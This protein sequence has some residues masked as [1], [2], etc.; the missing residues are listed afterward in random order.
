[1][2]MIHWPFV[3]VGSFSMLASIIIVFLIILP[4]KIPVYEEEEELKEQSVEMAKRKKGVEVE[5][6]QHSTSERLVV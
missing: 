6:S 2:S 3:I 1:M 5:T 4:F